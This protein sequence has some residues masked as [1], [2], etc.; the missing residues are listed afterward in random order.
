MKDLIGGLYEIEEPF[1]DE[2]YVTTASG[3][4]QTWDFRTAPLG[5]LPDGR[6]FV[7]S[8]AVDITE[9]KTAEAALRE[10]NAALEGRTAELVRVNEELSQYTHVVSHD[11]KAPL[12]AIHNY[13]DWLAEDAGEALVG[14][15]KEHLEG[16]ARSVRQAETL[17]DDLLE[18]SRVDRKYAPEEAV[19]LGPLFDRLV[20]TLDLPPDVEVHVPDTLPT[21]A[22]APTLLRQIFQNLILNGVTFNRARRKRIEIAWRPLG[23]DGYEIS[24]ADNGI[25]IDG[26]YHE[27]IFR[28]FERLHVRDE[29]PGSGVGLAIVKKAAGRLGGAVRVESETGRGATFHV[30]V[31]ATPPAPVTSNSVTSD[32]G[33]PES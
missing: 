14:E 1:E 23:K 21:V 12:R 11:L 27:Q 22:A 20:A 19:E 31:P 30:T 33:T 2:A 15:C 5:R 29:Y 26:K 28:I 3:E 25:G 6:R 9:R 7:I 8:M 32:P 10:T 16:L 17:I 4:R 13:S 18:L 24:V